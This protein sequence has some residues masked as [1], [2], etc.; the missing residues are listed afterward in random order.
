M[1]G[2][3]R[4]RLLAGLVGLSL[5]AVPAAAQQVGDTGQD[6]AGNVYTWTLDPSGAGRWER[7]RTATGPVRSRTILAERY[8]PTIW[9]DPDGCEHWVMDDGAEGYMTPHRTRD[10]RPVCNRGAACGTMPAD[11]F[12]ASDSARIHARGRAGLLQFFRQ[13]P[14]QA[15]GIVGH[16]DSRA[17][18]AYNIRLSQRRARAVAEIAR[19]AG[20]R[21]IEISGQG[22]AVPRATNAT[23]Q[24]RAQN[25]RVEIICY[26]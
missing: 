11:A 5:W 22:E 1:R 18:D 2:M 20:V 13:T 25:R 26:R 17:S 23:S 10:G 12:F 7:G 8:T 16:T 4:T 21:V 24:G 19:Q 9:T 6:A 14:A 3:G 15:F